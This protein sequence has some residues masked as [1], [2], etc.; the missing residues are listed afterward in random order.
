MACIC[1]NEPKR[2]LSGGSCLHH[3]AMT[4]SFV[5][6]PASSTSYADYTRRRTYRRSRVTMSCAAGSQ[7]FRN[8]SSFSRA[9]SPHAGKLRAEIWHANVSEN[10][11]AHAADRTEYHSYFTLPSRFAATLLASAMPAPATARLGRL[12]LQGGGEATEGPNAMGSNVPTIEESGDDSGRSRWGPAVDPSMRFRD[13]PST[14]VGSTL[15]A[16]DHSLR[17]T[18]VGGSYLRIWSALRRL[19]AGMPSC[20]TARAAASTEQLE[21]P[22]RVHHGTLRASDVDKCPLTG[23]SSG[24]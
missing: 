19:Q 11:F 9:G 12:Q 5:T 15:A 23:V 10:P 2:F 13:S 8:A 7:R 20:H 22:G 18:N 3:T 6:Q 17:A 24:L 14:L 16:D 4:Y 21:Q 1:V